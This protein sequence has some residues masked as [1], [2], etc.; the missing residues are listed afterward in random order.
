MEALPKNGYLDFHR[1][2]LEVVR[3]EVGLHRPGEMADA[4]RILD[5]WVKQQKHF[6][7]KDFSPIFLENTIVTSKGSLERAKSNLDKI[8]TMRTH[9]PKYFQPTDIR[10]DVATYRDRTNIVIS[11]Q[12]TKEHHRFIIAK[13]GEGL[14]DKNLIDYS[15][16]VYFSIVD[17][18]KAF[19]YNSG[20]ELVYDLTN[21]DIRTLLTHVDLMELKNIYISL[22][23]CHGLRVKKIHIITSSKLMDTL[24]S[25]FKQVLKR[26]IIDRISIHKSMDSLR[27]HYPL[28]M[29]P[30]EYGGTGKSLQELQDLLASFLSS[31]EYQAHVRSMSTALVDENLR[32][33]ADYNDK[34]AGTYGSIRS[35]TID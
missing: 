35:L 7:K 26:K 12:L 31:D 5:D 28:D 6:L 10:K 19:D 17:Y 13:F 24:L 22:M 16:R 2:T 1:D 33:S 25:F 20:I 18:M 9:L 21:A 11:P 14:D 34:Y 30:K 32:P 3:R 23:E 8:V 27:D 4:V 29:L 15:Y